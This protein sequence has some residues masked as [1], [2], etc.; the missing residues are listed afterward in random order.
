MSTLKIL[1]VLISLTGISALPANSSVFIKPVYRSGQVWTGN[2]RVSFW[3]D[4]KQGGV[5]RY[6]VFDGCVEAKDYMVSAKAGSPGAGLFGSSAF[7]V[8][9][10]L[11]PSTI[12]ALTTV[13]TALSAVGAGL[14]L[15]G[16]SQI[17]SPT[18]PSG[19]EL[20]EANRIQNFSFS[21][22]TNTSQQGLAVPIAYGRV[23]VGSA[24]ISSGL[25]VD[26][27]PNDQN[28]ESLALAFLL[29]RK[30]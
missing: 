9:G 21:G 29:R 19:L 7:G 6:P 3:N 22:I 5:I 13:G 27:S 12:G 14:V 16:V 23:V 26:H 10:P 2:A 8:F 25:D 28:E 30:S 24:V 15:T 20:K 4:G 17:I 1:G 18:P 11:A